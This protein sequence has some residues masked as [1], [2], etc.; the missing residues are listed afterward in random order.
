MHMPFCW[1]CHEVTHLCPLYA[2]ILILEMGNHGNSS[3]RLQFPADTA[4]HQSYDLW[5]L[6]PWHLL[7]KQPQKCSLVKIHQFRNCKWVLSDPIETA[8]TKHGHI[9]SLHFN[10]L[11]T[12]N[13]TYKLDVTLNNAI[14]ADN[15]ITGPQ[16]S[17][18]LPI[19]NGG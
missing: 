14:M 3:I 6:R 2:P 18:T 13:K 9:P 4:M 12:G 17:V 19:N 8:T 7:L 5:H 11:G 16:V 10:I 1:F 15:K